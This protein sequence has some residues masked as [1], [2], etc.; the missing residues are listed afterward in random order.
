MI[1]GFMAYLVQP[2]SIAIRLPDAIPH[3]FEPRAARRED[4]HP[5]ALHQALHNLDLLGWL[6]PLRGHDMPPVRPVALPR[7]IFRRLVSTNPFEHGESRC[8]PF[9]LLAV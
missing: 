8:A 2:H 7:F 5:V 1:L 3:L 4:K 9:E 6:C